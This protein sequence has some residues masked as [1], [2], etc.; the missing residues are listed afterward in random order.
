MFTNDVFRNSIN[1]QSL[2]M[3]LSNIWLK[4]HGLFTPC[5]TAEATYNK[6]IL[7]YMCLQSAKTKCSRGIT[8]L[9][10]FLISV[11]YSSLLH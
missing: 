7:E 1:G 8:A 3:L 6:P 9:L 10:T 4:K 2:K 11:K 5:G